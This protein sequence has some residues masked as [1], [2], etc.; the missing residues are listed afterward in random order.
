MGNILIAE[1]SETEGIPK[2]FLEQ[3]LLELKKH[4]ILPKAKEEKKGLIFW[5]QPSEI[6]ISQILRIIDG[7]LARQFRVV[8]KN[9]ISSM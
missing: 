7:P 6:Q 2:K 3:I 1:I 8:S 9:G 4:G 5:K